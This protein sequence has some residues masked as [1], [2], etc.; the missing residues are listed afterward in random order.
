MNHAMSR[1]S[2][3]VCSRLTYAG[4]VDGQTSATVEEM[5][6]IPMPR[7]SYESARISIMRFASGQAI[8]RAFPLG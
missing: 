8:N 5:G 2:G 1:E 3:A 6:S 4:I 7:T